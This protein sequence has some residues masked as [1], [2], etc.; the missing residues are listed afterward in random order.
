MISCATKAK[1]EIPQSDHY[2][3]EKDVFFNPYVK[4]DHGFMDFLKWIFNRNPGPWPQKVSPKAVANLPTKLSSDQMAITFVN[5][6][7]FL[8]Q[9]PGLNIL[10]DPIW[11]E[12]ASP[13]SFIGPKRVTPPGIKFSKLPKIDLVIISHNHYDHM[14]LSTLKRLNDEHHPRFLVPLRN[15]KFLIKEGLENV[16]EMDWW[17]QTEVQ[18]NIVTFV[19]A[20]HFSS[21]SLFDRNKTLWG[22]FVIQHK[23]LK[24]FFAGD[25]GY[26][27]HF[28][29][30][31]ERF[32]QIHLALI[33][34]GAYRPRWFMGPV[35]VDPYHAVKAHIDLKAKQSIGMH[36]GCFRL[37]DDGFLS[38]TQD[39]ERAK[40]KLQIQDNSFRVMNEGQTLYYQF[41]KEMLTQIKVP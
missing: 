23:E 41:T 16:E 19:P 21:R 17:E 24:I 18:S 1:E 35:H 29:E 33:P 6:A 22:G 9:V 2:D 8:I 32:N 3:I 38:P 12:R 34:I 26:S 31:A 27:P 28:K 36:F 25:T 10:T 5:H 15:K 11:S 40:I 4:E 20:Q 30:T 13:V 14:D 37:A 39:L 7:S